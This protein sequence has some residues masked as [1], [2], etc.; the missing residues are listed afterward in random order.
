MFR[1]FGPEFESVA[2]L[3]TARLSAPNYKAAAVCTVHD[4][5]ANLTSIQ[6]LV[7]VGGGAWFPEA[8]QPPGCASGSIM[9]CLLRCSSPFI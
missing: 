9:E 4:T 1:R 2:D 6:E 3:P 8:G 7:V 5:Q